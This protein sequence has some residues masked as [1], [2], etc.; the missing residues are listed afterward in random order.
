MRL[1]LSLMGWSLIGVMGWGLT[2]CVN[3]QDQAKASNTTPPPETSTASASPTSNGAALSAEP[4]LAGLSDADQTILKESWQAYKQRFIQNDGR[5]IDWESQSRTVSEGQA[6]AMLR[7]VW[8]D[9]PET[10]EKTLAWAESNLQRWQ[11]DRQVDSLWAWKWGQKPDQSWGTIDANFASDA[12]VDAIAALILASRRWNQPEYLT[13][14]RTKLKDLWQQA[15]IDESNTLYLLPGPAQAFRPQPDEVLLNPSYLFPSAFRLFAQV[16]DTHDWMRLVEDS[17]G[18]LEN[19]ATLSNVGLPSDW[20]RVN[21]RTQSVQPVLNQESLSS[22]YGFDAYRVWWRVTLDAQWFKEERA[23]A[24]LRQ[25]LDHPKSLWKA[26][27]QIPA[28]IDLAGKPL[29]PYEA[30]AQYAMLYAAFQVVDPA[31]AAELHPKLLSTYQNGIWDNPNAYYVQNLAW[32]G[33]ST[34]VLVPDTLLQAR[35]TP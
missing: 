15:V 21:L 24:F 27:Q 18:L 4:W 31:I 25:S 3:V 32:F 29:V 11:G 16:D 8:M 28:R 19:A 12:D 17:Y 33:L 5:V 20:V 35:P 14:A 23:I 22:Q 30:T 2:G 1:T 9:D 26:E 7:A 6:Y 10:F 13:L 34:P